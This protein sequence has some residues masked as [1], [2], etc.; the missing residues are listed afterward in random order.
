[1]FDTRIIFCVFALV[2]GVNGQ[3]PCQTCTTDYGTA[4]KTTDAEKCT[5][6]TT[7][8][9]CLETA[10]GGA[11]PCGLV[12]Q[13]TTDALAAAISGLTA[14]TCTALATDACVCQRA[15]FTTFLT[16]TGAADCSAALARQTCLSSA[17]ANACDGSTTVATLQG[18]TNTYFDSLSSC[19]CSASG[20]ECSNGGTCVT[21][22]TPNSCT[23]TQHYTGIRCE[24]ACQANADCFNG[25][26][27]TTSATAPNNCTCAGSYSGKF[28]EMSGASVPIAMITT[29][30]LSQLLAFSLK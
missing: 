10:A 6:V 16:P 15:F 5:A 17:T 4:A 1:M 23:C 21:T 27:C 11:N 18:N 28:C 24:D 3:T 22:T 29:A 19:V 12:D 14:G 13:A 7:Y 26:T 30:V 8:L 20:T 25:G 9:T 2:F